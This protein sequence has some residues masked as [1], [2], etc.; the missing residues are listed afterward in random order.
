DGRK[1]KA[2]LHWVSA[3]HAL[4]AEVRLYDKLFTVEQPDAQEGEPNEYLNPGSLE[5]LADCR[6]EPSVA[7][8]ASGT[9]Y[10]FERQGY[11]CIDPDSTP[12][13]LVFNR[14]VGLKD[15]WAKVS[16]K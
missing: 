6:V 7:G 8:A 9:R 16:G 1:V 12:Q 3:Q 15:T 4:A 14:A 2:T 11:F 10:Q 5:A 13:R